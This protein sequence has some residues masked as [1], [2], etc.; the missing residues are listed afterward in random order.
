MIANEMSRRVRDKYCNELSAYRY[1]IESDYIESV[2]ELPSY[3]LSDSIA[4]S[5][6]TTSL[7]F[8][9]FIFDNKY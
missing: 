2:I 9:M 6:V 8:C 4:K 5:G 3:N 1:Y 7:T